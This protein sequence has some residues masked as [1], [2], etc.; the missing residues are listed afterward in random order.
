MPLSASDSDSWL[1]SVSKSNF[2]LLISDFRP[3]S[4]DI[5]FSR[6]ELSTTVAFSGICS[7]CPALDST[8]VAVGAASFVSS[9]EIARS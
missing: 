8:S 3:E 7:V 1:F 2:R 9:S 4:S 5:I 6:I